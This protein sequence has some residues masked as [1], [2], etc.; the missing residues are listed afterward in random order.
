[1][2]KLLA[3]LAA[4]AA[5]VIPAA[6]SAKASTPARAVCAHPYAHETVYAT[7]VAC[8]TARIVERFWSSHEILTAT[9]RIAGTNWTNSVNRH[10]GTVHA[11]GQRLPL[12]ATYLVA[13]SSD[14]HRQT[15]EIDSLPYG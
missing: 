1:M 15:V 3:I 11:Y 9:V 2:M 12:Y 8:S 5:V 13:R 14:G 10:A 6:A 4:G 7:G